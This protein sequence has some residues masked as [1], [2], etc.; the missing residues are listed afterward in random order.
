VAE[1]WANE[2]RTQ[3]G[4]GHIRLVLCNA[5]IGNW[6][7]RRFAEIAVQYDAL[8]GYHPYTAWGW[9][10]KPKVRW[11]EDSPLDPVTKDTKD[12]VYLSGLWDTMELDWGLKP[13]WIFTEA[14]PFESAM[15]GWR[16]GSCLGNDRSLY[17]EAMRDW[18]R[19]VQQTPAYQEGRIYGFALFTTGGGDVWSDFETGVDEMIPLADMFSEEWQPGTQPPPPP[20]PPDVIC[21]GHPRTQYHRVYNVVPQDATPERAA[22]IFADRWGEAKETVGGSWDD[23]G[24]GDLD[25]RVVR[26]HD[27]PAEERQEARDWFAANYPGVDVQFWTLAGLENMPDVTYEIADIVDELPKHEI[28][29]YKARALTDITTLTIHHTVSPPSRAISSIA[30][31]H[32]DSR[33]WPGIG[34]HFV[35][36]DK[37]DIYQT[38]YLFT[39]SY[40]SAYNNEYSV[41]IALQGDFTESPPPQAQLDAAKWLIADLQDRL[42]VLDIKRHRDMPEAQ[43]ACPGNTSPDWFPDLVQ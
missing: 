32:V 21:R 14:G 10:G 36:N 35:I 7:D 18:L 40:H 29:N 2:Y 37:G 39:V 13:S 27:I 12:W 8:I 17:V 23:A 25:Y 3:P 30:T 41:G 9:D 28:K 34:Y 24:V 20:L 19:D 38:N 6:I 26:L 42:G 15:T 1:V 33:D 31:Y 43:T 22:Q 16:S 5:A 11:G 4:L